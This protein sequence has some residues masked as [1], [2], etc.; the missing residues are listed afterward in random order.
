MVGGGAYPGETAV[1]LL[2]GGEVVRSATGEAEEW[3]D[4]R[5]W[6]VREFRGQQA[7]VEIVD[8]H[9]GDGGHISVDHLVQSDR[10]ARPLKARARWVDYGKDFYAAVS[11]AN[12]A[13]PDGKGV[14]LGWLSNWQ[15]ASSVPTY[16]W[17]SAQSVPRTLHL[18]PRGGELQLVQQPI[19]ALRA[20]RGEGVRSGTSAWG[21]ATP[22]GPASK[23][24]RSRWS[25]RS[26]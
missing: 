5:S 21:R 23:V 16:P 18:E 9:Q 7:R 17:R 14:W 24:R 19:G 10:R 15:Y 1:N 26:S 22:S 4:W 11:W 3:L 13:R 20:L 2:V 6:D 12:L 8:R 25:R